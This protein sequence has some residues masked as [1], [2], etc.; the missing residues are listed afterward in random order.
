MNKKIFVIG[1]G[2]DLS[3]QM[4]T[5]YEDFVNS[6]RKFKERYAIFKGTN[7][8]D[9]EASVS[10]VIKENILFNKYR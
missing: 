4:K 2:F 10:S 3:R 8:K 1:N 5:R 7:W 6:N 9:V